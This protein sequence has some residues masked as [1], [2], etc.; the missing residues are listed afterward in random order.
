MGEIA[1]SMI[2]GELCQYCGEYLGESV[3]YPQ[4]CDGCESSKP[5]K[6]QIHAE[7][8]EVCMYLGCSYKYKGNETHH[9]KGNN[10]Y[11]QVFT[12]KKGYKYF[13]VTKQKWGKLPD[14]Y[15]TFIISYFEENNLVDK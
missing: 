9:L 1:E 13:D 7:I 14:D 5:Y 6:K 10:K 11:L 2:N 8:E 15:E 12:G 4:S 3:G